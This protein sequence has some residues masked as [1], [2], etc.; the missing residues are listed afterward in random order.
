MRGKSFWRVRFTEEGKVKRLFFPTFAEA[1]ERADAIRGE[2]SKHAQ[3]WAQ[4]PAEERDRVLAVWREAR[5]KGVDLWA[6]IQQAEPDRVVA[7]KGIGRVI[8]EMLAA[9]QNAG[10]NAAYLTGLKSVC[11]AFSKGR[12]MRPVAKF[13]LEDV[14][15]FLDARNIRYRS[16]L[17]SRLSTLFK[18]AIRRRYRVDNPCDGLDHVTV[19]YITPKIFTLEELGKAMKWLKA[20]PRLMAWFCLSTFCGLRPEEAQKTAWKFIDLDAGRIRVEAQTSKMGE[21]R[22]VDPQPMAIA[23]LKRAKRLGAMLPL[24][25]EALRR[26]RLKLR[27]HLGWEVW[28]KDVTRHSAA[29][30]WLAADG[31]IRA[32]AL[33]L[34]HSEKILRKNYMALVT[35]EEAEKFW[36]V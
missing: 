15:S 18:F 14:E 8:I 11:R 12:V 17:R 5:R 29:S 34:G 25:R 2:G 28:P 19:P 24:S 21:R 1:D 31:D 35:K 3:E 13:T 16:T 6:L 27:A 22:I 30:Y 36:A 4:L 26:E 32:V 20:N 10:R 7:G 9:K 23:W 33:A